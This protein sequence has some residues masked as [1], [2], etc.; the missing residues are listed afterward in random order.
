MQLPMNE[1][2][3]ITTSV[4]TLIS[5]QTNALCWSETIHT[6]YFKYYVIAQ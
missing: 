3:V 1:Q 5:F 6:W 2:V 4:P